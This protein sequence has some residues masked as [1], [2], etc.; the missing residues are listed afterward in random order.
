MLAESCKSKFFPTLKMEIRVDKCYCYN[1][2]DKKRIIKWEEHSF[3]TQV[4]PLSYH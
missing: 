4:G 1:N 2:K 3:A